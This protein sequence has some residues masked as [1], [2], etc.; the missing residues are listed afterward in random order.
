[1]KKMQGF[2]LIELMIVIAIL[3]ILLAIAIPAYNDYTIRA[4]VGEG[5]NV[6]AATKTAVS[7]TRL[8]RNTFPTGNA[9][10]GVSTTIN[11]TYVTSILVGAG[12]T[13]QI[14]YRNIDAQVN[15]STIVLEP[16]FS[17]NTVRWDCTGG[18]AEDRFR[19]ANCR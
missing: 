19:P 1:M 11:S 15:S 10:A 4:R 5:L 13:I 18:N 14:T 16:T 2:T 12:G 17:G 3:G 6:A 8:S 7:E 9:S